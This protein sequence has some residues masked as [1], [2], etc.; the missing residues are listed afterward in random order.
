MRISITYNV[1]REV[2]EKCSEITGLEASVD[3][4]GKGEIIVGFSKLKSTENTVLIQTASAGVDHMDFSSI[5]DN[6]TVCSNAG[7]YSNIVSEM[8]FALL[9]S[10]LKKIGSFDIATR[11]GKFKRES[12]GMLEGKTFG[13]LGYGGIGRQSARIAKALDMKTIAYSRSRKDS[14]YLDGWEESPERLFENSDILLISTPLTNETSGMVD[15][16]L[17]SRFG[18][19]YI[20][21]IARSD[22]VNRQDMLDYLSE[23]SDR[24]YLSDVWWGEP[25]IKYPVPENAVLTPHVGGY[26]EEM[27]THATLRACE[28]VK[29][30]LD[31]KPENVVNMKEYVWR[32]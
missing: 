17:L 8:V 19:T 16:K 18:G 32:M 5:G 12:I 23:N 25:E 15:R 30:F 7:A 21:N 27:L 26:A 9:L 20:I 3:L 24:F 13:V 6:V 4:E 2:V 14:Q 10:H 31:G 11:S 28:N 22:V 29:R 1:G